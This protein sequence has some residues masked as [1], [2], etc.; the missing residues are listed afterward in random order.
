MDKLLLKVSMSE[1]VSKLLIV[2]WEPFAA[3]T[4]PDRPSELM[5]MVI[6]ELSC[7]IALEMDVNRQLP[8]PVPTV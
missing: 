1:K 6:P 7:A 4:E 2:A 3:I 8:C 5:V